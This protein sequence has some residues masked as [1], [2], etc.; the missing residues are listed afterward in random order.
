MSEPRRARRALNRR[1]MLAAVGS[2]LLIPPRVPAQAARPPRRIDVHAHWL[3]PLY[4]QALAR[5][6]LKTLDGG[7]PVP[8]WNQDMMLASMDRF[9]ISTSMLSITSPGV[10][11]LRPKAAVKLARELNE[12]GATL[13]RAKPAR[14]GAFALLPMH[15]AR[16][17]LAEAIHALD[18]LKLDGVNIETNYNGIY[19]GDPHY[20]PLFEELN[21]R[22][23]VVFMHP[24]SPQCLQQVGL[25]RPGPMLEFPFDSTRAITDLMFNGTL[26]RCPDLKLI[27]SH[28]GGTL[29]ILSGRI[30]AFTEL[31]V[32]KT[33]LASRAEVPKL[34]AQLFY[35]LTASVSPPQFAAIRAM[36]PLSQLLFGSDAP[37]TPPNAVAATVA[38]L[39]ALPGLTEAEREA[40]DRGN[41]LRLFPRLAVV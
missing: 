21:R 2:L 13:M 40:I 39:E 11:F 37:F 9:R 3:P 1:E 24:T 27:V 14:I 10:H 36:A 29:P 32:V 25:G 34:L 18:V 15:D 28:G 6:G 8:A 5:A 12:A 30:A 22:K 38:G 33:A 23:A 4:Q 31:E 41:A 17:A 20:L 16:A 26:S 35:D 19:P 7:I